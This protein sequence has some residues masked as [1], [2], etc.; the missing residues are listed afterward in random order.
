MK[1]QHLS[2]NY[3][4]IMPDKKRFL[5][6]VFFI[7]TV[8]HSFAQ[9]L[10]EDIR[11]AYNEA[12]TNSEKGKMLTNYLLS[13]FD[14]S[15]FLDRSKELFNYF[16][17]Q[18]DQSARDYVQLVISDFFARTG[19]Y[20]TALHEAL[21]ILDRFENRKDNYGV[22]VASRVVSIAYDYAGE[23]TKSMLF[24]KKVID[25]A[26][27]SNEFWILSGSYN[28]LASTLVESNMPDSALPYLQNAILYADKSGDAERLATVYGTLGEAYVAKQN[29]DE[30]IVYL[31]KATALKA[32]NKMNQAWTLND[33]AQI[34]LEQNKTD[35]ARW[36][37]N[38]VVE[39]ASG[40]GYLDQLQRAY[41]YLSQCYEKEL[42]TDSAFKYYKL[43]IATKDS[44]VNTQ[45]TKQVQ[46]ILFQEQTRKQ[47]IEQEKTQLQ[48]RIRT[49]GLIAG[50]AIFFIIAFILYRNNEQKQKANIVLEK[51]LSD[52]RS[53]QSQL[54]QAEK[55]ASLGEL[56][57]G[58]AHEI[59]NPL[60]FVNNF[61]EV[62]RELIDELKSQKENL[63]S[64][65]QDEILDDIDS[66]LDKINFHGKR[67]DAIVKGMLQHSRTSTG[68]KEP[69]DINELC[70]EY[71]RLSYHGIRAKDN[72]F[73][74]TIKTDFD[75]TIGKMN[76]IPQDIGR[77]LQNLYNNAFY[78][79]N[80][81]AK[82]LKADFEPTISV[83]TR[84]TNN[85]I[86]IKV[87]DNGNGIPKN[88]IDKIFQPFFTTKPTGQGTGLGLSIS[89]DIIK[90]HN[91]EIRAETKEGEGTKFIIQLPIA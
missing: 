22:L 15:N 78:A 34:F 86:E 59:Q 52:L 28:N 21:T 89:Y 49:Y 18:N 7:V 44:L 70:D 5:V 8:C 41:Q 2:F 68:T 1:E 43:T 60:N 90:A 6:F 33:F 47:E 58:I 16:K 23:K 54:I 74:A 56:T 40:K 31:N 14:D 87:A 26:L 19:S 79:V 55:M 65:E 36:Y 66:N 72:S 91:G 53:T 12:K 38:K 51:T 35:S 63:Q 67:A 50:L 39:L 11:K 75:R 84:K 10:P 9:P 80:E 64:E 61:S 62:S 81:K 17:N 42:V 48:N 20:T 29:F 3:Q 45:K 71:L 27:A 25:M 57:A 46:A 32:L 77:V 69:A 30:A 73:N 83:T 24:L 82:Q 88:I 85:G 4:S 76:I 37:A 13:V